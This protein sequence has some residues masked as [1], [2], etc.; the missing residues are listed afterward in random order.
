[1]RCVLFPKNLTA[2]LRNIILWHGLHDGLQQKAMPAA[3][4]G[5]M[6]SY[7]STAFPAQSVAGLCKLL[8]LDGLAKVNQLL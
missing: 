1:M 6:Q 3:A 4:C 2:A 8:Y 5:T 7:A